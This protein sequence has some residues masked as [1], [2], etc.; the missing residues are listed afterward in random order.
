LLMLLLLTVIT[1]LIA[2]SYPALFMSSLN[3]V[4][5]LKGALKFKPEAAYFRKGLVVFQFGLSILLILS[6]IV[7][8]RQIEFIQNKNL[9]FDREN[10]LYLPDV[11]NGLSKNFEAFKQALENEPGIKSVA[12]SQT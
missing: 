4:T 5:I 2:G 12:A 10:L 6:M 11:E 7:I 9:G 1:G 3:P 8:Y